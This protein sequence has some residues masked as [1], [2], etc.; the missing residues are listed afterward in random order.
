MNNWDKGVA[1]A[2]CPGIFDTGEYSI[3]AGAA[4]PDIYL[5]N[6]GEPTPNFG[7]SF[8]WLTEEAGANAWGR[9]ALL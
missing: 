6:L 3:S 9:G 1:P 8:K 7:A 5:P 4:P 2:I